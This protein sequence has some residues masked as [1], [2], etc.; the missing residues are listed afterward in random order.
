MNPDLDLQLSPINPLTHIFIPML[1]KH[2]R[3]YPK[4]GSV[5]RVKLDSTEFSSDKT[6]LGSNTSL[7]C[8]LA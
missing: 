5:F 1:F 4:K 8:Y 3:I 2:K 6:S 7:V